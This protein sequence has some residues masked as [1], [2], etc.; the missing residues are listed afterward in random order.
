MIAIITLS[1]Q[2]PEWKEM[3]IDDFRRRVY[4]LETLSH[5]LLRTTGENVTMLQSPEI[6]AERTSAAVLEVA[7]QQTDR[8]GERRT[9][10]SGVS[11]A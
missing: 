10:P 9:A 1:W 8:T 5:G 3:L 2:R 6:V 7:G 11:T 4:G